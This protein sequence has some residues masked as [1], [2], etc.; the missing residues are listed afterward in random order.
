MKAVTSPDEVPSLPTRS[1]VVVDLARYRARRDR[2]RDPEH[3]LDDFDPVQRG[4][5][6]G[7]ALAFAVCIL[8]WLNVIF[9][10]LMLV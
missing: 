1:A 9:W 8:L 4:P 7:L 10:A 2:G 5:H 3:T 6:W